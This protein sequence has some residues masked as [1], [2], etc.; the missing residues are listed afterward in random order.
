MKIQAFLIRFAQIN[1]RYLSG[2]TIAANL[3]TAIAVIDNSDIRYVTM[4]TKVA[5]SFG[6]HLSSMVADAMSTS[7]VV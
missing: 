2:N 1:S 7:I 6:A 4:M 5:S 3:S